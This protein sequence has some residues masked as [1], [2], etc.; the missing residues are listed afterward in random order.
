MSH[1]QG[2]LRVGTKYATDIYAD[3]AGH[4]I[5]R[6]VN[7]QVTAEDDANA[8]R[9]VACWNACDGLSTEFLEKINL[10]NALTKINV[11]N[12][13]TSAKVCAD[14]LE[15]DRHKLLEALRNLLETVDF[16]RE[17]VSDAG[18]R[19]TKPVQL[20]ILRSKP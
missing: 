3:R 7:P 13:L 5:A 10:E 16:I 2:K 19:N 12:A 1:T 20:S 14:A 11:E 8:R 4:A 18:W 17:N 6:T 15:L 9:L